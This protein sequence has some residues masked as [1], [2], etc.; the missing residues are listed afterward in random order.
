MPS[1]ELPISNEYISINE[2]IKS[3]LRSGSSGDNLAHH[4]AFSRAC[5]AAR[6]TSSN[7]MTN[8]AAD[9]RGT[10]RS[11]ASSANSRAVSG[12]VVRLMVSRIG[13]VLGVGIGWSATKRCDGSSWVV[14]VD[15]GNADIQEVL[16]IGRVVHA[17]KGGQPLG[18][19][20][21]GKFGVGAQRLG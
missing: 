18:C 20:E 19:R 9:T 2:S 16:Q 8:P 10:R 14:G 7:D 13:L 6:S 21:V 12:C 17:G 5:A 3:P 15:P 11:N 1:P 4:A